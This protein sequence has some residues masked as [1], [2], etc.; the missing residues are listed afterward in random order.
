MPARRLRSWPRR[1]RARA[2]VR[3]SICRRQ[4]SASGSVVAGICIGASRGASASEDA[5]ARA[6][7]RALP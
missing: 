7:V 2:C 4:R 6:R 5:R 1:P 3:G